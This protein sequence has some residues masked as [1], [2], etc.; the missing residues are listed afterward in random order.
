MSGKRT[1]TPAEREEARYNLLTTGQVAARLSDDN[2]NAETVRSW[3]DAGE[4]RAVDIRRP[5]AKRPTWMVDWS[6]VEEFLEAR[7]NLA[8]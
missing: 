4:L 6:W 2:V 1:L 7:S 5:G 3:I 8:A